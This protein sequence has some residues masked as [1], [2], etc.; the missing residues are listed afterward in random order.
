MKVILNDGIIIEDDD[1]LSKIPFFKSLLSGKYNDNRSEIRLDFH[2]SLFSRLL[3]Y[4][5]GNKHNICNISDICPEYMEFIDFMGYCDDVLFVKRMLK[6]EISITKE[7]INV[8]EYV[9]SNDDLSVLD[10]N[11]HVFLAWDN[12]CILKDYPRLKLYQIFCAYPFADYG[13]EEMAPLFMHYYGD[14]VEDLLS[15]KIFRYIIMWMAAFYA[16]RQYRKYLI[17]KLEEIYT[18]TVEEPHMILVFL[19]FLFEDNYDLLNED[20]LD[21]ITKRFPVDKNSYI[22]PELIKK[23]KQHQKH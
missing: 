8:M 12:M 18:L 19:K 2:I 13:K 6:N 16:D 9:L 20:I 17:S 1:I 23:W 14:M 3:K 7:N 21:E 4:V 11:I 10:E 5:K 15:R 22:V